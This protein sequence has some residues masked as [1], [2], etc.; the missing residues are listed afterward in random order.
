MS[1]RR[2]GV[3]VGLVGSLATVTPTMFAAVQPVHGTRE[4]VTVYVPFCVEL[5]VRDRRVLRGRGKAVGTRHRERDVR[6]RRHREELER[7]P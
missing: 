3:T 5:A 4:I 1:P 2:G 7:S 6:L